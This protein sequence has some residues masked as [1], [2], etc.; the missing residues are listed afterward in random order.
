MGESDCIVNSIIV[1]V[2]ISFVMPRVVLMFSKPD[3]I[4]LAQNIDGLTEKEKLMHLMSH[5]VQMPVTVALI[6]AFVVGASVYLG[7]ILK[8]MKMLRGN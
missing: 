8:P 5:K 1:G 2:V 7:Y 3:E 4:K 6:V